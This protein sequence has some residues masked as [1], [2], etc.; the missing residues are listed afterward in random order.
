MRVLVTGAT[1]FVGRHLLRELS[2][3]GPERPTGDPLLLFALARRPTDLPLPP[4]VVFLQ[5]DLCRADETAAA[6]RESD[7]D[8]VYHLAG[9]ASAGG[10]M[11]ERIFAANV[12][13]S[14]NLCEA[15]LGRGQPVALVAAS[16]G[17]VYGACDEASPATEESPVAPRGD[18][19]ESKA[20]MEEVLREFARGDL[21]V[22]IARPFNH[23]G[24]GQ[25]D[26]YAVPAFA[27]QI[28]EIESGERE[29]VMQVGNL[30]SR[31]D[32]CD[33][34]D[35][36]RA[37]R[38]LMES[39]VGGESYNVCSG[40]AYSLQ[41]IVQRLQTLARSPFETRLDPARQRPSDIPVNIG[42]PHKLEQLSG[43]RREYPLM[44]TLGEVLDDWRQRC[45][46]ACRGRGA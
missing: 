31:R 43:W 40:R 5:A 16:T 28:A 19:A 22:V 45:G 30:D 25:G 29:P 44:A 37:Y 36:V 11:R 26:Q 20:R 15:L 41:E 2:S 39:G 42:C 8:A 12:D 34:R 46:A 10:G 38:L 17:Y 4:G 35:V 1:G 18:Y 23:T 7:P 24:P 21:R 13:A 3:S 6:V 33:V 32:F 9:E 14:R 27:R